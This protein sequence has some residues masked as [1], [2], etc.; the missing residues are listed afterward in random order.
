MNETKAIVRPWL[1]FARLGMATNPAYGMPTNEEVVLGYM[2]GVG[3][4]QREGL[5]LL[6]CIGWL[7][8]FVVSQIKELE[9]CVDI[10]CVWNSA[11][12]SFRG[13]EVI[14]RPIGGCCVV[15]LTII[16]RGCAIRYQ[17][18]IRDL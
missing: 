18:L 3:L 7:R 15:V 16:K 12:A 2:V 10:R 1:G 13:I 9:V 11:I 17:A 14:V 5:N 6:E 4:E 8:A